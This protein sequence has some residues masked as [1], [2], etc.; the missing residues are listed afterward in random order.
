[1]RLRQGSNR[2]LQKRVIGDSSISRSRYKIVANWRLC[3]YVCIGGF[4]R[5]K[6]NI[7]SRASFSIGS[8]G[9][10]I[11]ILSTG[12]GSEAEPESGKCE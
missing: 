9:K 11:F 3:L 2:I 10:I 1:M 12:F 6:K 8:G 5:R 7:G 4:R